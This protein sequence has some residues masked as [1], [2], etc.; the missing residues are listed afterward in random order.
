MAKRRMGSQH[1]EPPAPRQRQRRP[2]AV[3]RQEHR[4]RAHL[5]EPFG[6]TRA[7]D[8]TTDRIIAYVAVRQGTKAANATINRELAALKRM[9]RLG[10]IAGKV[11]Q[12]PYIPMLQ[13][14]NAR[15]GFFEAPE[16]QA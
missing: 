16:F 1:L 12:R 6:E 7:C 8:L 13:E 15:T 2:A 9:F 4:R 10:E 11:A 14:N 3:Q 5:A